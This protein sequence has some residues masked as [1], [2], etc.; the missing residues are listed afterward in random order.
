MKVK[1]TLPNAKAPERQNPTDAG[2]DLFSPIHTIIEPMG[3][4]FIDF[5]VQIELP[6]GTSGLIFAR[7]GLGS[8]HG[9]RPRNGVGLIDEKYRGNL[10]M[11]VENHSDEPFEINVGDRIAQL[12]IYPTLTPPIEVV[13]ELDMTDDRNGGFGSTG[14]N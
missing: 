5:G 6:K 11:M 12:G 10:G 8:K 13:D 7:S 1:L 9:I 3:N 4:F 14:K 2:A